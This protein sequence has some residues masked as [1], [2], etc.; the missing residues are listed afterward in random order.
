MFAAGVL[1]NAG[2]GRGLAFCE[3]W[4]QCVCYADLVGLWVMWVSVG[5]D[6]SFSGLV[7]WWFVV[8]LL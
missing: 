3:L 2:L 7:F 5:F 6:D 4:V 1:G 8:L